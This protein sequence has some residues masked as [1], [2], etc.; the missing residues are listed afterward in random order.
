[1]YNRGTNLTDTLPSCVAEARLVF[2][3]RRRVTQ[4]LA[5]RHVKELAGDGNLELLKRLISCSRVHSRVW[6]AIV[7]Q[8]GVKFVMP[9][10]PTDRKWL[11]MLE[12]R[13][14]AINAALAWTVLNQKGQ[15]L[16]RD[17]IKRI[18]MFAGDEPTMWAFEDLGRAEASAI[19]TGG[20]IGALEVDAD[21]EVVRS[22]VTKAVDAYAAQ[23]C[24]LLSTICDF[25]H[26]GSLNE[27]DRMI[28]ERGWAF[29]G[30]FNSTEVA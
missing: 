11:Q 10:N 14:A 17:D 22:C 25:S 6:S 9:L 28:A 23:E 13:D 5:D 15:A 12:N 4:N 24:T 21:V 3:D 26:C 19:G 8:L 18:S 2:A 27:A 29:A 30:Q 1:L 16:L 20:H 7:E